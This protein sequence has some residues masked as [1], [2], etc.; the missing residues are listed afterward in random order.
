M[1]SISRRHFLGFGGLAASAVA[2]SACGGSGFEDQPT[3]AGSGDP[4][5]A[6]ADFEN[7]GE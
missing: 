4:S 3:T 6:S 1:S 7:T 2:L 5:A